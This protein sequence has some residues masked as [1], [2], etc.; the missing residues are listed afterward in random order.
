MSN[1]TIIFD[2]F[3]RFR[4]PDDLFI[5]GS[6]LEAAFDMTS[7]NNFA[8]RVFEVIECAPEALSLTESIDPGS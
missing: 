2:S 4:S 7:R 8:L 1:L 5:D 6:H 3:H